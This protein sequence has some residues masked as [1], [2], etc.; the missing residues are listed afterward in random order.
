MKVKEVRSLFVLVIMAYIADL[1][2]ENQNAAGDSLADDVIATLFDDVAVIDSEGATPPVCF[3]TNI[4]TNGTAVVCADEFQ[5]LRLARYV[6]LSASESD[7]ETY[8]VGGNLLTVS[9]LAPKTAEEDLATVSIAEK[10]IR[11]IENK[12][13]VLN[14]QS[15]TYRTLITNLRAAL[16]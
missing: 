13:G 16:V 14:R 10:V 9:T 3:D 12:Y 15:V 6:A 7:F 2:K 1:Y 4:V 5:A 8:V 11:C